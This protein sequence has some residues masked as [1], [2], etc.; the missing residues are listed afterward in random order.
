MHRTTISYDFGSKELRIFEDCTLQQLV[1]ICKE[2]ETDLTKVIV[3]A[4]SKP[5]KI[6]Y[7]KYSFKPV[8]D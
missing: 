2:H 7:T 4:S 5:L 6:K 8:F 3:K 1:D